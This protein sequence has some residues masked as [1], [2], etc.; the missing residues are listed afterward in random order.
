MDAAQRIERGRRHV[1]IGGLG[2]A[3]AM[4]LPLSP[5][6]GVA[7]ASTRSRHHPPLPDVPGMHGDRLANEF[8]YQLD[9]ATYYHP[10]QELK[11]AYGQVGRLFGLPS[12]EAGMFFHWLETSAAP[13]YPETFIAPLR[14]I[15]DAMEFISRLQIDLFDTYYGRD[16]G[17]IFTSMSTL[18]QGVLFDPRR[19]ASESEVHTMNGHPPLAYHVWHAFQYANVLMDIDP[20]FWRS[21]IP[22]NGFA[23]GLQLI[24]KPKPR[25]VNPPVPARTVARVAATWLPRGIREVDAELLAY[26]REHPPRAA[27]STPASR[28]GPG[29][30]NPAA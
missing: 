14:S 19:A 5:L 4:A 29:T 6:T 30:T 27:A 26:N 11:D 24:A 16:R 23:W 2:L 18:A 15:R 28:P 10:S 12:F 25:M 7:H 17:G 9:E 22:L 3:G 21:M 1:L 20:R 13:G 8:W